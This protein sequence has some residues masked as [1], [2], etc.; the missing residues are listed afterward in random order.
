MPA[1]RARAAAARQR[2]N[3]RVRRG[4]AIA[5][6]TAT[7]DSCCMPMLACCQIECAPISAACCAARTAGSRY[8]RALLKR[9]VRRCRVTAAGED[10]ARPASRTRAA[11]IAMMSSRQSFAT[12]RVPRICF[13]Y[14]ILT[15]DIHPRHARYCAM[16]TDEF[17]S[18]RKQREPCRHA[19]RCRRRRV[20]FLFLPYAARCDIAEEERP[21]R[22]PPP[23]YA[24]VTRVSLPCALAMAAYAR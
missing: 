5:P 23:R 15:T 17:A 13:C 9:H 22:G 7:I 3:Q 12:N 2:R 8:S 21:K 20:I 10:A 11:K 19:M 4:A 14:P 18:E 24:L 6:L 16:I 1:Q